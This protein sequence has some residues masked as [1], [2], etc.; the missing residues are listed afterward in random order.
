MSTNLAATAASVLA[1]RDTRTDRELLTAFA[2]AR[3]EDAFAALVHRH[4]PMVAA[5]CRRALGQAADADDAFQATFLL[6]ARAA[7][8]ARW[9]PSVRGWL[10]ATAAV[11]RTARR[12]R[13]TRVRHERAAARPEGTNP[14]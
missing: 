4:G 10:Y 8:S 12:R 14:C 2:Q 7:G 13:A 1:A 3:N 11:A 6:L 5:V 9:H